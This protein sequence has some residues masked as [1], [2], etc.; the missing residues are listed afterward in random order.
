M[1]RVRLLYRSAFPTS[2]RKPFSIIKDMAKKGRTDLF[3]FEDENGF[4]GM[5]ATINGPDAILIDYL[6]VARKRRGQGVG[7]SMLKALLEHYKG[8]GVFLEIE[9]PDESAKNNDERIRRRSFYLNAGFEPMN[10]FVNLF[11]VN[12]ELL[13]VGCHFDFDEYREFYLKNYSKFAYDNIK[14]P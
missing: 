7:T 13:G 6:A 8:Y 10:T 14:K 12:M 2:E 3:C 1:L 9:E 4:A 5:C 11:G